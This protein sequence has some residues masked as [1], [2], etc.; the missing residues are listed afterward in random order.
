VWHIDPLVSNFHE[1]NSETMAVARKRPTHNSEVLMV[2]LFSMWS[3]LK[4]YHGT[5]QV[6]FSVCSADE[7]S[8]VK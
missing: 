2:A 5:N 3:A 4:L 8:R 7:Y 1:T 6:Q